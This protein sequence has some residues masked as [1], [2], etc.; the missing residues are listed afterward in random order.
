MPRKPGALS[1]TDFNRYRLQQTPGGRAVASTKNRVGLRRREKRRVLRET[2]NASERKGSKMGRKFFAVTTVGGL[3]LAVTLGLVSASARAGHGHGGYEYD[4]DDAGGWCGCGSCGGGW[5]GSCG[6]SGCGYSYGSCGYAAC[7]YSYGGCGYSSCGY[8]G[9]YGYYGSTGYGHGGYYDW[10][11]GYG[12]PAYRYMFPAYNTR[13][14]PAYAGY[15]GA[16]GY[17]GYGGTTG[18]LYGS[19]G[20]GTSVW[21]SYQAPATDRPYDYRGDGSPISFGTAAEDA[22]HTTGPDGIPEV[23]LRSR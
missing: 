11:L 5:C 12:L 18:Y 21:P 19:G 1:I 10:R 16:W 6:Y 9:G 15:S 7:D 17:S 20:Y 8:G 3:A 13:S 23:Q 14:Y 2:R 4:D 22:A